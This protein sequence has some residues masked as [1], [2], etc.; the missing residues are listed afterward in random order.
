MKIDFAYIGVD[1]S[2]IYCPLHALR[3]LV[4][5]VVFVVVVVADIVVVVVVVLVVADMVIVIENCYVVHFA[6]GL[7]VANM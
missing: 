4:V 6:L 5:V 7:Y 1:I 2:E 3:L